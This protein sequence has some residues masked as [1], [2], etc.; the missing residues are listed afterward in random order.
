MPP[1]ALGSWR[2]RVVLVDA[3]VVQGVVEAPS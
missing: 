3:P 2:G 1:V